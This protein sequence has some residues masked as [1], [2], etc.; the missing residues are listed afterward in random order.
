MV[1][2]EGCA[3]ELWESQ[4]KGSTWGSGLGWATALVFWGQAYE[5]LVAMELGLILG[6]WVGVGRL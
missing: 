2:C 5:V 3:N 6:Q 4:G 1:A